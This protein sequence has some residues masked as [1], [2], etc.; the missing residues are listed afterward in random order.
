MFTL[1]LCY[2]HPHVLVYLSAKVC[3][4]MC[5]TFDSSRAFVSFKIQIVLL[6]FCTPANRQSDQAQTHSHVATI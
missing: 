4:M 2:L 3:Q 6:H 1:S 5:D